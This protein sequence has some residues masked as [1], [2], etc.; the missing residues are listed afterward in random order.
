VIL[1]LNVEFSIDGLDYLVYYGFFSFVLVLLLFTFSIWRP[2]ALGRTI[3]K[4]TS[5]FFRKSQDRIT[6]F[7]AK[8]TSRLIKY[9]ETCSLYF[10][11]P[12]ILVS[13]FILTVLIFMTK[14]SLAY[15]IVLGL[16]V[17][18]DYI[19]IIAI[20]ILIY[21]LPYFSPTPGGSCFTELSLAGLMTMCLPN[22]KLLIFTFLHRFFLLYIPVG[23]GVFVLLAE[24]KKQTMDS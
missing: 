1:F 20:Q 3:S 18:V 5:L 10:R 23:L 8:L 6:T 16:S 13:A 2:D 17:S 21:F 19:T 24:L 14:F 9:K 11:Q 4:I 22:S 7:T 15:F 12:H